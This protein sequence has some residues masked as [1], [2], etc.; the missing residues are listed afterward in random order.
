[1]TPIIG[2]AG[3]CRRPTPGPKRVRSAEMEGHEIRDSGVV[4]VCIWGTFDRLI[5]KIV[6]GSFGAVVSKWPVTRTR[7]AIV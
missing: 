4:V 6:S 7:L 1:M 3:R 5:L 2:E